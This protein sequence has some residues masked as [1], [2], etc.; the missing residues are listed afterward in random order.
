QTNEAIKEFE[1]QSSS[2]GVQFLKLFT[3]SGTKLNGAYAPHGN[4]NMY[5]RI[6]AIT[7]DNE[8]TYYSNI[9]LLPPEARYHSAKL[10]GSVVNNYITVSTTAQCSFQLM[11]PNGQLISQGSIYPGMNVIKTP[12]NVKGVFLLR[13]IHENEVWTEKILKQ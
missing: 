1:V 9:I 5:Y 10:L 13:L 3:V 2:N 8:I 7:M 6:K 12:A 4:D 11:M